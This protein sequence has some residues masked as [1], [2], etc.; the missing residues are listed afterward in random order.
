MNERARLIAV[1]LSFFYASLFAVIGIHLP[2]WPVWLKAKGLGPKEIAVVLAVSIGVKVIGNPA[3]AH[4][5]DRSGERRRLI[6]GLAAVSWALFALYGVSD[7]F[8]TILLVSVLFFSLWPAIMPLGESLTMHAVRVDGLDYG[9]IR[10]WGSLSFIA[11]AVASGRLLTGRSPDAL[12]WILLLAVGVTVV[13][14][15]LLPDGRAKPAPRRHAPIVE[16][17]SRGWFV[18]FLAAAAAVQGSHGVYYAFGTLHWRSAGYSNELIGMLWAE[19]VI[20]EIIL[21]IAGDRLIRRLGAM[22]LIFLAG[23]CGALRWTLTGLSD[24]LAVVVFAQLLHAFTFG[25]CHL[26]AIHTI[27]RS[28]PAGL[29][30]TAQSLYSALVMGLGLGVMLFLSGWLY[31]AFGG[32]AYLAM[33]GAALA[34]AALAWPL[35]GGEGRR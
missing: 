2:F 33:A 6:V 23:V 7:E 28:M 18:L 10:L 11:A 35:I 22:R 25:A 30:A 13:A 27:A 8:W 29:S 1:R 17:L 12:Y 5:A 14:G 24:A 3:V 4:F 26:G 9:R 32:G 34:G 19:G 20:A 31:A 21:F 15:L 16:V